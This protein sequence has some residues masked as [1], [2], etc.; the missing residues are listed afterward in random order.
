MAVPEKVET[1]RPARSLLEQ[2]REGLQKDLRVFLA[3][4]I[5]ICPFSS[6][7]EAVSLIVAP[8]NPIY[9]PD[10]LNRFMHSL[11]PGIGR[12]LMDEAAIFGKKSDFSLGRLYFDETIGRIKTKIDTITSASEPEILKKA[13]IP[14]GKN[15]KEEETLFQRRTWVR[16]YPDTYSAQLVAEYEKGVQDGTVAYEDAFE[17][18]SFLITSEQLD[19]LRKLT[20]TTKDQRGF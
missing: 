14:L 6:W 2:V 20:S 3:G 8:V 5:R 7:L 9:D 1:I 12:S 19:K 10:E 18:L 11:V 16:V 15:H 17:G 13:R 4:E